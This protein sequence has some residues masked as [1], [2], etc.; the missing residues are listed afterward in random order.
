MNYF[1]KAFIASLTLVAIACTHK[2]K[3]AS[4]EGT[5]KNLPKEVSQVIL[6]TKDKVKTINIE[7]GSFK[8]TITIDGEF[9]YLQ[10]G[11]F[12]K[13]LFLTKETNLIIHADANDYATS[14]DYK[15]AGKKV[16]IYL[17][18]REQITKEVFENLDS[19]NT[20]D[21]TA[22]TSYV[23]KM[24]MRIETLLKKN[25]DIDPMVS[26]TEKENLAF[27]VQNLKK[28]YNVVNQ[29]DDSLKKGTPSPTFSNYEN[30]KGGTTSLTDLKGQ[31]V[32]IDI[33]ATWCPPCKAEIPYLKKLEEEFKN[34]NI[35]FVSIS[36][37]SPNAKDKWK[38]MIKN[39]KMSGIQLFA[40]GDQEFLQAYDVRGIP[41]FIL[42][43]TQG[44][45]I[46]DNAP[47]PSGSQI[48][49][50]IHNLP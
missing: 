37:D 13:T 29:I 2:P 27:F 16:N 34:K 39:K 31:Y 9:A 36:I 49:E 21:Q 22:F 14:I 17:N 7:N 46:D 19:I 15:G 43:D 3:H 10:I 6:K 50:I 18:N 38:A 20:L 28:Q 1:K 23:D 40:N 30:Y 32:Y 44:N 12:G 11:T 48:K 4:I 45:I 24:V 35:Q 41:R 47:R 25:E 8:D 26:K 5:I 33:W 42:L